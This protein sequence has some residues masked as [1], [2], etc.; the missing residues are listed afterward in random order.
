MKKFRF[1][2]LALAVAAVSF[3]FT[4]SPQEV[5]LS[6]VYAFTA[7]GVYLGSAS[8]TTALKNTLCTG[9]D[10]TFCAQIWTLKTSTN[11]PAGTRLEDMKKPISR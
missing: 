11:E 9:D 5:T 10:E 6:S 8:S 1:V 7:S 3:A 2:L 4:P